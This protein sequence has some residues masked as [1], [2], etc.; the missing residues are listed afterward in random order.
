MA[1]NHNPC[2]K[3]IVLETK[4]EGLKDK[5]N[6]LNKIPEMMT[7]INTTL[8]YQIENSERRDDFI[9]KQ[10]I[11]LREISDSQSK[12]LS[13]VAYNVSKQSDTIE[14]LNSKI[15]KTEELL[16]ENKHET[17]KMLIELNE[18]IQ[19]NNETNDRRWTIHIAD[20]LQKLLWVAIGAAALKITSVLFDVLGK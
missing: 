9:E 18:K 14:K 10:T 2:E 15:D 17:D 13:D 8:K 19:N 16:T 7:E 11:A 6:Y 5:L 4:V 12:A 3:V 20:I 1:D